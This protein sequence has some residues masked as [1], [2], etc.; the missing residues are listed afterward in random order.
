MQTETLPLLVTP[1][2]V[3]EVDHRDLERFIFQQYG[4]PY[5]ITT[6]LEVSSSRSFKLTATKT[7]R[8]YDPHAEPGVQYSVQNGLDPDAEEAIRAWSD[9]DDEVLP[10]LEDVLHHLACSDAISPGQYLIHIS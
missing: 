6:A 3:L 10:P 5:S 4:R 7:H 2:L 1:T 8:R 9:G